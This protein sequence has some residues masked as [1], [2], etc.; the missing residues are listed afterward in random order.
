MSASEPGTEWGAAQ[1]RAWLVNAVH[2]YLSMAAWLVHAVDAEEK[3]AAGA[4][5]GID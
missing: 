4:C 1:W 2:D 5:A 3:A